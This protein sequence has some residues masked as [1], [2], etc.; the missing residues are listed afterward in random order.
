MDGA[1]QWMDDIRRRMDQVWFDGDELGLLDGSG[2]LRARL[3]D[4][5]SEY[6]V[7]AEVPGLGEKDVEVTLHQDVLT[8]RG[9][10]KADAPEGYRAHRQE[11]A[12]T[13]FS[14]SFA[15]PVKVDAEKVTARVRNGLLT[16]T[17]PKVP[18]SQPRQIAVRPA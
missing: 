1:F 12:S 9:E 5:G 13:R 16:V 4:A 17:L 7:T 8:L 11:R 14:R 6:V 15:L 10:R 3:R 18:E 2:A